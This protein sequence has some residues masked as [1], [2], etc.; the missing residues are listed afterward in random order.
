MKYMKCCIALLA[1]LITINCV[2]ANQT[3]LQQ[4]IVDDEV[5]FDETNGTAVVEAEYFY[6]QSKNDKRSWYITAKDKW[7][8]PG[9][10]A[11][12]PHCKNAS[13]NAYVEIL[14]DT[15]VSHAD[16][17]VEFENF[18]NEPGK[19]AILHY[20]VNINTPGRYYVW[21]R[22]H[23]T[24]SEDNG[25]HVGINGT[26]PESGMRLQW[27]AGKRTWRWESKQR[28]KKNHC[29]EK[30]KIYLDIDKKGVHDIQ[31]SMRE[32]GFEF[33]QFILT[34][35]TTLKPN[36]DEIPPVKVKSG[37]LPKPFPV[38]K[39]DPVLNLPFIDQVEKA[40]KGTKLLKAVTFPVEDNNFYINNN[41]LAINPKHNKEAKTAKVFNGKPGMYDVVFLAVGENDGKSE[42]KVSI[43]GEEIGQFIVPLSKGSFEEGIDYC[44]LWENIELK[45]GSK[46]EVYAKVGTDGKEFSRGR[47]SGVA[48][49]PMTKGKDLLEAMKSFKKAQDVNTQATKPPK[50]PVKLLPEPELKF[51]NI[52]ERGTDGEGTVQISGELKQWHKITLTLDGPFAHELDKAPNPFTDYNMQVTFTHESGTPSYTVPGYFAADGDAAN[53]GA[54]KGNKW[55]AHLSPDKTGKWSYSIS[56]Q[57]GVMTAITDVPWA[58]SLQPFDGVKGDF[59][60]S[61]S[62]KTGRDFRSKGRLEYVGKHHLQFMGSKEYFLKVGPDAPE[63]FLAYKDFDATYTVK[64]KG[65]IKKYEKHLKDYNEGDPTWM[66]GKG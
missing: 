64:T 61:A 45:K 20:K 53:S 43:D 7:A 58:K 54:D 35:D 4:P 16:K 24:G 49:V 13:N 21:L 26:W 42:Y 18:S 31:F 15:R 34:N 5:V 40:I 51:S 12:G 63:T 27:C 22:A 1:V 33:D 3:N 32:D 6:K 52:E 8:R 59:N 36:T 41:W 44:E 9:R 17:L 30:W 38:V 65:P 57:K 55:R 14:P 66:N 47:W 23:S 25:I 56:F 46:V 62:D 2:Y 37:T 10:D 28:T 48:L 39:E 11:D 50:P 19:M 29:G 60:I